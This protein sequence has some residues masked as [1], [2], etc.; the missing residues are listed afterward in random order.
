MKTGYQSK[1]QEFSSHKINNVE[2]IQKI[3]PLFYNKMK[4]HKKSRLW[5]R[6]KALDGINLT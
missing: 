4:T 5:T 1:N 6:N 2:D 3:D